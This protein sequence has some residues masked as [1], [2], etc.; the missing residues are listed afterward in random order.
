MTKIKFKE[1]I[2]IATREKQQITYKG[3]LKRITADL[4]AETLQARGSGKYIWCDEED[5]PRTKNTLHSKAL[6]QI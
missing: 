6:S 2:L 5:Q 3:I 4:S 1:K